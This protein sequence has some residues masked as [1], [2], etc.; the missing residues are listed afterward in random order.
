MQKREQRG[1]T[2]CNSR[3]KDDKSFINT[4]SSSQIYM[5][6]HIFILLTLD[7]IILFLY[8]IYLY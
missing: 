2:L 8:F 4:F 7:Y 1:E 3:T 5:Q 6:M